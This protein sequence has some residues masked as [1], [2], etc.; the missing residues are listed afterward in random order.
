MLRTG[1]Q[2]RQKSI[3]RDRKASLETEVRRSKAELEP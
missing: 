1:T 3:F 2:Y